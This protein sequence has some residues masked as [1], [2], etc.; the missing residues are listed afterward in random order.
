AACARELALRGV[1]ARTRL[2]YGV[3]EREIRAEL[4]EG[5]Y[6]LLVIGGPHQDEFGRLEPRSGVVPKLLADLPDCPLLIV[7]R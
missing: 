5:G 6:D 4:A 7:R 1:V 3:P 2:R